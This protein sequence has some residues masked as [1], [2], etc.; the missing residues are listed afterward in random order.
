MGDLVGEKERAF[1]TLDKAPS[2]HRPEAVDQEEAA[3]Y[4][5]M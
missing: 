4:V 3:A 1:F 2:A 5:G